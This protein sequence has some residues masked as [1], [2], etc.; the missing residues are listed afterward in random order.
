M[1]NRKSYAAD[2][3]VN[4]YKKLSLRGL[5]EYEKQII[6][7]YFVVGKKI[8]D[9]GCGTGRTCIALSKLGYMVTGVDYSENMIKAARILDSKSEYF[10]K[11]VRKLSFPSFSFDYA[12]FS[13]N[14]LMLL[15]TY[16]DRKKAIMEIRRVLKN[17]GIFFFTTPFLD[18]KVKS[19]YWAKK[20]ATYSHSLEE[21]SGEEKLELGDD[22]IKEGET[23]FYLHIPFLSE[24]REMLDVCGYDILFEGR[25]LDKF[26]EEELE[27]E[28]DDNYLWVVMCR[29]V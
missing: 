25:R 14:G 18:N 8:I 20:V 24:I 17:D 2:E 27:R 15:E 7:K 5:F 4:Y 9:I 21:L 1:R 3:T 26:P 22:I 19:E 28:L 13:F 6:E 16:E 23:E 11:D 12:F 29:N 10:V